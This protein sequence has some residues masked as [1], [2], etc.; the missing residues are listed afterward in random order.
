MAAA[1]VLAA[2]CAAPAAGADRAVSA[3][4]TQ[5]TEG[6]ATQP[7][8]A[9][10]DLGDRDTVGPAL[11][12]IAVVTV[13]SIAPAI[14]MLVT[15]FTRIVVVL[16]LLRHG[17]ATPQLPPNSVLFGLAILM[18]IVAMAPVFNRIHADALQPYLDGNMPAERAVA[19][20]EQHLRG[21]MIRQ[22]ERADNGAEVK[23]FLP[24]DVAGR[25]D[26]RWQDVPTRALVP[27]YV[28]SELKV[29]F[30]IGFRILLPFLV[31]DLLVATVLTSM[32]VLM[33]PPVL[34]SLPLKL[35]LF[36]LA[37]G[38]HLVVGTLIRGIG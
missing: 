14:A 11:R 24:A 36:V 31:V 17:L 3:A 29:A 21:F 16:G 15:C 28:L 26:L 30:G 22:I 9:L 25:A 5:P 33:L 2:C 19:S 6:P 35:L 10:P 13:I 7:A 38:W 8:L 37:D 20:G 23:V 12:W 18:T 27:G 32:G 34:I 1:G 4:S